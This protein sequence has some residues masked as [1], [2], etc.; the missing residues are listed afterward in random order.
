[1]LVFDYFDKIIGVFQ[2]NDMGKAF[3]NIWI[4]EFIKWVKLLILLKFIHLVGDVYQ[5]SQ[6]LNQQ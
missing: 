2:F 6:I 1:L 5:R 4:L 3:Q